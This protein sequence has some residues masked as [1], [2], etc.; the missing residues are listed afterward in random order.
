MRKEREYRIQWLHHTKEEIT[1][2]SEEDILVMASP[3]KKAGRAKSP[4]DKG[5]QAEATK[6]KAPK[7]K[8]PKTKTA[9][10]TTRARKSAK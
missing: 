8:A 10:K 4:Q 1:G 5:I 2:T 3:R 6:A 9:R 7:T